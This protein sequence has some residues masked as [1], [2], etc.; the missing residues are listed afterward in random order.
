MGYHDTNGQISLFGKYLHTVGNADVTFYEDKKPTVV[1]KGIM[2]YKNQS[3][4]SRSAVERFPTVIC[5]VG[6]H[7]NLSQAP[8]FLNVRPKTDYYKVQKLFNQF[9]DNEFNW[10]DTKMSTFVDGITTLNLQGDKK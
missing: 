4:A 3:V 9:M 1:R 6:M 10:A 5:K 7:K 8:N 2:M